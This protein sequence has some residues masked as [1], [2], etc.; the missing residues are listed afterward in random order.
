[1]KK[2]LRKSSEVGELVILEPISHVT[3]GRPRFGHLV[4]WQSML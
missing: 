2:I 1:L 4:Y 3:K